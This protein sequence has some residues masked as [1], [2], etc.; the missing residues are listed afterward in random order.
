M[1][2]ARPRSAGASPARCCASTRGAGASTPPPRSR[3]RSGARR[4]TGRS[5]RRARAAR[6]RSPT[7][8]RQSGTPSTKSARPARRSSTTTT[9]WPGAAERAQRVAPDVA[10]PAGD[11]KVRQ[12]AE[13]PRGRGIVTATVEILHTARFESP[14]G[15]LFAASSERGLAYLELAH[16]SGRGFAGWRADRRRR[17][18]PGGGLRAEPRRRRAGA[19]VPGGQA[20]RASS[21]PST[22]AARPSS[23]RV[24]DALLRDPVRR[25]AHLPRGRADD[26]PARGGAR[27]RHRQRREPDPARRA[28]PPRG[29]DRRSPRRL[30]RRPPAQGAPPRPREALA[31]P[32]PA[33]CSSE[34]RGARRSQAWRSASRSSAS[35]MPQE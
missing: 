13:P 31:S 8:W 17:G 11:E 34:R 7:S 12:A 1:L 27:R 29:R 23:A 25:D 16:A 6:S 9:R 20:P 33:A 30:R 24:W 18:A 21:C 35:S 3:R 15:T 14:I 4:R 28:L 19:R 26:R 22:C 10:R 5:G 2:E 32:P